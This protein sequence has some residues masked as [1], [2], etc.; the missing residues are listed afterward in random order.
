MYENLKDCLFEVT[1][2]WR[3]VR[4]PDAQCGLIWQDP[5]PVE[6]DLPKA[7]QTYYTHEDPKPLSGVAGWRLRMRR[8]VN[9]RYLARRYGAQTA[10]LP[11]WRRILEAVPVFQP[12]RRTLLDYHIQ[13]LPAHPPGR[14]LEIGCGSGEALQGRQDLGWSVEGIEIDGESARLARGRGIR[15]GSGALKEQS[16]APDS[17]DAVVLLHLIEHVPDP[18]DLL[19]ESHRILKSGGRIV[20]VTPNT[21]SLGHRWYRRDWRGLEPPRHLNIFGIA[22]FLRLREMTGFRTVRFTTSFRDANNLFVASRNIRVKH[23]HRHGR[24]VSRFRHLWSR[25]LQNWE[26]LRMRLQPHLGEEIVWMGEK[27]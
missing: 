20:V 13:F 19:R 8:F 14:L 9:A 4:C 1:G 3:L 5:M 18:L 25:G 23:E 24:P 12:D 10:S 22:S 15:V 26:W 6:E 21:S 27:P 2:T 16:F 7:Y 11:S 17:F